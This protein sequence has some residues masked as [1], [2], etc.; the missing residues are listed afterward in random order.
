MCGFSFSERL[1]ASDD[2]AFAKGVPF[3]RTRFVSTFT[4]I[5]NAKRFSRVISVS[6]K[7]AG[8]VITLFLILSLMGVCRVF[9]R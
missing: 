4:Y 2:V 3:R 8:R 7:L 5:K 9:S 6:S 1:L